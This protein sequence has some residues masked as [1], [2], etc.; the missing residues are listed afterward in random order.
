MNYSTQIN[1]RELS[2]WAMAIFYL[3]NNILIFLVVT[4]IPELFPSFQNFLKVFTFNSSGHISGMIK[5]DHG[6][7]TKAKFR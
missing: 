2:A 6:E 5:I 7:R 1:F 3:A 4:Y